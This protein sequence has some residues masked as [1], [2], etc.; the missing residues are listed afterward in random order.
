M[1]VMM[2]MFQLCA[3]LALTPPL[4]EIVI[5]WVQQIANS[6][7]DRRQESKE[8]RDVIAMDERRLEKR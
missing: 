2:M 8:R 7:V 6:Y 1:P 3:F 5:R 4:L